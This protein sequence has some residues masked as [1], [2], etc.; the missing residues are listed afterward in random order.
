[1]TALDARHYDGRTSVRRDAR[2]T[3][4]R[5]RDFVW[6]TVEV[7]GLEA[8]RHLLQS[9]TVDLGVGGDT[10][11]IGLPDG[12]TLEVPDGR[13]WD[14]LLARHGQHA[15]LRLLASVERHWRATLAALALS[16]TLIWAALAYGVPALV[17]RSVA[18]IPPA[19]DAS[20][21][22][23]GLKLLDAQLFA[24]T[25]L[26]AGRRA[27]LGRSFA[28]V[29]AD[30]GADDVRLL[31]R[32]GR[33]VGANAFALP[34]G[35]V[36]VTDELV[37]LAAH[38][39]ELRAVFAHEIGHVRHRHAMRALLATSLTSVLSIALLGDVSA[40]TTLVTGVPVTLAHAANSRQFEREADAVARHWMRQAGV[41][42]ARFDDLL[43]RLERES[44][45]GRWNY[46]S[47]HPPLAERLSGD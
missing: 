3:L 11:M 41:P 13:A 46:L 27:E 26:D 25:Q 28:S 19:T 24:P 32:R 7:P 6:L 36:I 12:G 17:D 23:G 47:T 45:S 15:R 40:A 31:F 37:A 30:L 34:D 29:A 16:A 5:G 44:G 22:A 9:C 4:D 21:A 42:D 43:E 1:V 39:D 14:S 8:S 33:E 18:L 35:T 10:R 20:I 38:E 2:V